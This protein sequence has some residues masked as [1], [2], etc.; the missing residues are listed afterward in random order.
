MTRDCSAMHYD[1]KDNWQGM[2]LLSLYACMAK[3]VY[4]GRFR[5][6]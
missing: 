6:G 3:A 2:V 1:M 4:R 5:L